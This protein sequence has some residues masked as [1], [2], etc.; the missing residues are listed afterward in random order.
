MS[1]IYRQGDVLLIAVAGNAKT[2]KRIGRDKG[3]IVLA[4]GEAT[5]HAHAIASREASLW[6]VA[7]GDAAAQAEGARLLA[8]RLLKVRRPV[9]LEH[10]EHAPIR[11]PAGTY[12]VRIQRT[13]E[14]EAVRNVAD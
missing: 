9:N 1:K 7:V 4:Y 8:D 12:K 3:R 13:Y 11:L 6:E 14:P 5:G 10:E 2:S